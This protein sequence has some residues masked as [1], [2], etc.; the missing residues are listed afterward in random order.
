MKTVITNEWIYEQSPEEVWAYLT[1]ADLIALWLM[2]NNFKPVKGHVFQFTVSPIPS[3][4]LDGVMHCEVLEIVPCKKL[5]Y[6]WKAGPGDGSLPLDTVV[7]W[8]LEPH[9]KGAKLIVTQ[10]GF[11]DATVSIFDAMSHGWNIQVQKMID[12]LN[13]NPNVNA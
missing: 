9:G 11:N 1:N 5:V 12:H 13:A 10:S 3:L 6:T 4:N 2:P 7:E 8:Q